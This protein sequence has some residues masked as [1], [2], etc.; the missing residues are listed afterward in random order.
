MKTIT[1]KE[2]KQ[3]VAKEVKGKIPLASVLCLRSILSK[4]SSPQFSS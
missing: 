1:E 2:G 3:R 4:K